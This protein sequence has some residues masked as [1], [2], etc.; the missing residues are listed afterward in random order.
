[1]RLCDVIESDIRNLIFT[2]VGCEKKGS[3]DDGYITRFLNVSYL[4]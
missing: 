3:L 2:C 1:M 4:V